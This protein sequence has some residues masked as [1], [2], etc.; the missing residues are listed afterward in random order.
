VRVAVGVAPSGVD[1]TDSDGVVEYVH[2][3]LTASVIVSI[4]PRTSHV[5]T[6]RV[7]P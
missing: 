1:E 3:H 5:R 2:V 6:V 7:A 4:A